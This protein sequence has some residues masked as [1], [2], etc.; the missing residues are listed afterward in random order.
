MLSYRNATI[1]RVAGRRLVLMIATL[2]L[3]SVLIF[4]LA[5]VMPGDLGRTILGPLATPQQVA[6]VDKQFGVDRPLVVRYLSWVSGVVRGDWGTS[7]LTKQA[8][9]PL[10]A[11]RLVNSIKLASVAVVL[12]L[13]LSVLLGLVSAVK[14]GRPLDR[15]ISVIGLTLIAIPEFV[16][17]SV[18]LIVFSVEWHLFPVTAAPPP[19]AGFITTLHYLFLPAVPLALV[20][21]G[22]L[23]RMTRAGAVTAL[24]S[25]Y[26]RTAVVKGL[27]RRTVLGRHILRNATLPTITVAGAQIGGLV[28]GLVIIE[29]LFDYPGLGS[30]ILQSA[31]SHDVPTLE[32]ATLAAAMVYLV[33][34]LVADLT[35][36]ALDPRVR[37]S[38]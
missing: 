6:I 33:A 1:L 2:V 11:Q 7:Y 35:Y 21:F 23:S 12:V 17:G 15:S 36:A 38:S 4:C 8:V 27:P 22:Y 34:N 5:Q 20:L 32:M 16:S 30:L 29:T 28:G 37:R 31:T 3:L 10:V 14:K 24:E 26:A 13:P 18:L 25:N 9:L 19:G